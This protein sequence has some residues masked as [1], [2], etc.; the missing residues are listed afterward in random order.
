MR[1]YLLLLVVL[2][3]AACQ[4]AADDGELPTLA[5]LSSPT[6]IETAEPL[7]SDIPP[8]VTDDEAATPT[9]TLTPTLTRTR[10]PTATFTPRPASTATPTETPLPMNLTA[11]AAGTATARVVEA[12][13][14]SSPTPNPSG[15]VVAGGTPQLVA[16]LVITEGQFQEEVD[17][18][19]AGI[20]SIQS[21]VID[22]VPDGI[23]VELTALGGQAFITGRVFVSIELVGGFIAVIPGEITVN[24]L[25]PPEAYVEVVDGEFFSMMIDVLDKILTLRLGEE[26]DLENIVMTDTDMA[27]TLLVPEE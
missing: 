7:P 26:H 12:P 3:L 9:S 13:R 6:P 16:D 23:N 11:Q 20:E 27:V 14:L 25:E 2:L 8:T 18:A 24:A 10:P 22:F 15:A 1:M 4:P 21:A 17:L 19:V 5:V